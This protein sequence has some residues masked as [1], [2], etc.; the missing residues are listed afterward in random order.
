METDLCVLNM[1][2]IIKKWYAFNICI[3]QEQVMALGCQ[4]GD[5]SSG[6]VAEPTESVDSKKMYKDTLEAD[7]N[8][9]V[10]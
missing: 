1:T 6:S 9:G 10:S 2:C 7:K 3:R 4:E 8:L 5:F